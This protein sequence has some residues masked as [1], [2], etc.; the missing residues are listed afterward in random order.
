MTKQNEITNKAILVAS[1]QQ[2]KNLEMKLEVLDTE[3]KETL[4]ELDAYKNEVSLHN[5]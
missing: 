1:D 3:F 5:K 2:I 4:N